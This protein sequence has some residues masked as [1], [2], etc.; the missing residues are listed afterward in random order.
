[1]TLSRLVTILAGVVVLT[2]GMV[3]VPLASNPASAAE[4]GRAAAPR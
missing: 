3:T 1:M 4:S 2:G